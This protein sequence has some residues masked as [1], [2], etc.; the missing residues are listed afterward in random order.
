[1]R[2]TIDVA[3]PS[4]LNVLHM[5]TSTATIVGSDVGADG[6]VCL[7]I[8]GEAVPDAPKVTCLITKTTESG[9][10]RYEARFIPIVS[11][12]ALLLQ[13]TA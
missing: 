11:A 3:I 8:E 5:L 12:A 13:P 1:M 2:S 4:L 10:A 7:V 9:A 6:V